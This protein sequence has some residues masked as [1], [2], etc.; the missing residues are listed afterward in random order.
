[1]VFALQRY[2]DEVLARGRERRGES[3][4]HPAARVKFADEIRISGRDERLRLQGARLAVGPEGVEPDVRAGEVV[5]R[6][7]QKAE[8]DDPLDRGGEI[9]VVGHLG[10]VHG[11]SRRPTARSV[12]GLAV[13]EL[14][15]DQL[16]G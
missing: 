14:R 5:R 15:E 13:G 3:D 8:G 4:V 7:R 9:E 12:G 10:R 11:T 2:G 16:A 1:L 6:R